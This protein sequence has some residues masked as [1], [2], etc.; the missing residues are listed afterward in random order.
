M[1]SLS[2]LH[3]D[4]SP[5]ATARPEIRHDGY[6]LIVRRVGDHVSPRAKGS[7]DWAERYPRIGRSGLKLR[8]ESVALY[9]EVVWLTENGVSD[10]EALHSRSKE[11]RLGDASGV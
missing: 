3:S 10:F 9:G 5:S 1:A 6:R 2:S 4:E 11:G 8:V 7:Y